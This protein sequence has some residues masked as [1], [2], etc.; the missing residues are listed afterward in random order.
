MN[1]KYREY[2]KSPQWKA[3]KEKAL[4]RSKVNAKSNNIHGV[5]EK[6]GYEPWRAILQLHHKSYKNIYHETLDDVV[7]ICPQ[8]HKREHKLLKEQQNE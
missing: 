5:C 7:L 2:L 6:C 3:L 4:E 8:C 1:Q